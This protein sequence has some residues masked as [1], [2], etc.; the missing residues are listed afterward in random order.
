MK[1]SGGSGS[2]TVEKWISVVKR[3]KKQDRWKIDW[4]AAVSLS[5]ISRTTSDSS[6]EDE[7]PSRARKLIRRMRPRPENYPVTPNF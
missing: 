1:N 6:D 3:N 4:R 7:R 5:L 2:R